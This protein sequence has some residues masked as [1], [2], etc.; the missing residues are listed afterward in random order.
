MLL[1]SFYTPWKHKK[2]IGFLMFLGGIERD[3]W[4]KMGSIKPFLCQHFFWKGEDVLFVNIYPHVPAIE[5][6]FWNMNT[7]KYVFGSLPVLTPGSFTSLLSQIKSGPIWLTPCVHIYFL[8]SKVEFVS[9][10]FYLIPCKPS[11]S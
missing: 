8:I 3:Q 5:Y 7:L 2:T 6:I 4:H 9:V 1:I 11:C 10:K